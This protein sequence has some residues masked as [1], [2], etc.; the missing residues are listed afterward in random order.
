M[1]APTSGYVRGLRAGN[2]YNANKP[3][4]VLHI[5]FTKPSTLNTSV[6]GIRKR[7]GSAKLERR[8]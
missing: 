3:I 8:N 5:S 6:K 2:E 4:T 7:S 1:D